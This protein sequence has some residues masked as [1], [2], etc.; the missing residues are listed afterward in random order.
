MDIEHMI[1]SEGATPIA[2]I[3]YYDKKGTIMGILFGI[4]LNLIFRTFFF[5]LYFVFKEYF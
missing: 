5:H 1:T 2:H 3:I 4:D